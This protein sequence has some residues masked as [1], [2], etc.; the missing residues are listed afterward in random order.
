MLPAWIALIILGREFLVSGL[1]MVAAAEGK[2][3][4]ASN[5]GKSKTVMQIVAV[6]VFIVKGSLETIWNLFLDQS[7]VWLINLAAWI[8]MGLTVLITIVSLVDYFMNSAE[9]LGF[10]RT[11]PWARKAEDRAETDEVEATDA[12]MVSTAGSAMD[13]WP[14]V[15]LANDCDA[16]IALLARTV[17]EQARAAGVSIGTAESCTGGLI[18]AA[19]T[20]VAGASD[21]FKG[22]IVSY[23]NTVKQ[24]LLSVSADVLAED[25]AVSEACVAQMANQAKKA[26]DV[27][28]AVA[29]SGIAGPGGGTDEKPVGLIWLA[30]GDLSGTQTLC[31]QFS[32]GR[33]EV[34]K[35]AV[36]SALL[37]LHDNLVG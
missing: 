19:L 21:V 29:V 28:L 4:A 32:G 26:L 20:D 23:A 16:Q 35:Q 33:E 36:R 5:L 14:E 25:G 24:D 1:R 22:A 34:R 9:V 6:V 30:V 27:D 31:Q 18:A 12:S 15:P 8:T 37:I 10:E 17:V 7:L 3:I 2:V 13:F 11:G